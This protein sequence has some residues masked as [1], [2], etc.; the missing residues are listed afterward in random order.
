MRGVVYM[1]KVLSLLALCLTA[2]MALSGCGSASG[3]ASNKYIKI[4]KYDG[5]EVDAVTE[6]EVTDD[7][8]Q[9]Y[10]D[11]QLATL[12][13]SK[14]E[15]P[16][17]PIQAGDTI[18]L[19]C[20][21]ADAEGNVYNG[22]VLTDYELEIGSGSFIEGWEDAC[23]GQ[24]FGQE[25][26]FNLKF[27]EGYGS[28]E[29]SGKDAVWTVTAKGLVTGEEKAELN[30]DNA[31]TLAEYDNLDVKD[32][33]SYKKA[34]KKMLKEQSEQSNHDI[35][36][37]EVWEAVMNE[38]EVVKYPDGAVDEKV[39]K[40]FKTYQDM[41]ESYGMTYEEFLKQNGMDEKSVKKELKSSA[42]DVV[43][44]E[45]ITELLLD[46][47][48]IKISKDDYTKEYEKLATQYGFSD[49]DSFLKEA[50]EEE[51]KELV[52]EQYVGDWLIEHCKQVEPKDDAAQADEFPEA[53]EQEETEEV[54]A[55]EAAAGEEE[56]ESQENADESEADPVQEDKA[57][58]DSMKD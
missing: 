15:V 29:I 58:G 16:D 50:G 31:K 54:T 56:S 17:R 51:A 43:K 39:E 11:M 24:P 38:T 2:V 42:E 12:T 10:I 49:A 6:D 3:S 37:S 40:Y 1:R 34:V 55:E 20:S 27:P 57:A 32:V 5:L 30:D 26:T 46:E 33:D 4:N 35:L 23:I 19:D 47:L 52:E 14:T 9:S 8:V 21:A 36:Y 44:R 48:N 25:F 13:T 7:D 53:G 41:A 28:E 22:T 45:L 18:L